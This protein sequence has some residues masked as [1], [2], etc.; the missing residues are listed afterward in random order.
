MGCGLAR[1]LWQ[2]LG[3]RPGFFAKKNCGS[4][5]LQSGESFIGIGVRVCLKLTFLL[6]RHESKRAFSH[7][8]MNNIEFYWIGL[9]I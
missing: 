6:R 9:L 4:S 5:C 7:S 3:G 8:Q 2:K 1:H